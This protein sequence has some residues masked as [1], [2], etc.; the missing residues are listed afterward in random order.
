MQALVD[1]IIY[2]FAALVDWVA[3]ET[4]WLLYSTGNSWN[5]VG[6]QGYGT[7]VDLDGTGNLT[8][9]VND[10]SEKT[11]ALDTTVITDMIDGTRTNYGF[12]I[13]SNNNLAFASFENETMANRPRLVISYRE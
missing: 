7:D 1:P 12:M 11:I 3:D 4:T 13:T 6:A 5:T 10:Y 2:V 8:F 9:E